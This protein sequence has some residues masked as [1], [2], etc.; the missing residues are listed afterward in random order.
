MSSIDP[1]LE[2]YLYENTQLLEQLE[3]ILLEGEKSM[4]LGQ[5]KIAEV[6]RIM[7]TI[8][9]SSAMMSYESLAH[10]SHAVEDLFSHVR[11]NPPAEQEWEGIFD[12]VL[13]A[14]DFIKE[15]MGKL[16][17][18]ATPDGKADTLIE[19]I[20]S[21]LS[22]L[23]G[24]QSAPVETLAQRQAADEKAAT[25]KQEAKAPAAAPQ[26]SS[27]GN[28]Y[29]LHLAFEPNSKMENIRAFGVLNELTAR[30]SKIASDPED[31]LDSD[32]A[33]D[34]ANR[35]CSMYF[36]STEAP[37]ALHKIIG[38]TLFLSGYELGAIPADSEEIPEAIREAAPA[39]KAEQKSTPA[40]ATPSKASAA[41]A[42]TTAAALTASTPTVDLSKQSFISVNVNRLDKLMDLVGEI[43][44]TESMVTKNPELE[45]LQLD[46][47]EKSAQMLR[48]LTDELQD[49]VM[50]IRMVPISTTFHKMQRLVRD[51]SRKVGKDVDLIIIGEETEIDKSIND[52]LSD[53]LMHMIRNSMDH[54]IESAEDRQAAGKPAKATITLEARN[55]GGDVMVIVSDDGRGL[56]R[57][58]LVAKAT[59]RGLLTKPEAEM[60]DKEV[61]NLILAPGFSTNEN[62]TEYSGRGVG[63]DVVRKNIDKIG[64][65]LNIESTPGQGMTTTI[66]IPL[67]LAIVEGMRIKVGDGAFILPVLS[68]RQSFKPQPGE[69]F[70]DPDGNEMIMIRGECYRILRLHETFRIDDAITTLEE[71]ILI[72]IESEEDTVC[73]FADQLIGEQQAVVKPMPPYILRNAGRLHGMSGCTVLGDGSINLIL[74]VN[75][76]IAG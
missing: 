60:T 25:P 21:F 68:I 39:P 36:K 51:M 52:N 10:L 46:N 11:E 5:E 7:H 2:V 8:K 30:S 16:S 53:P 65:T 14:T 54:G 49:I 72:M 37:E 22:R 12:V 57:E 70:T 63:M 43:V 38:R 29:R 32:T 20:R 73:L 35:G 6:F 48:K 56:N 3:S 44:T 41:P 19:E 13:R 75:A 17:A 1:M 27:S 67:T 59:E 45:G 4:V 71:G 74:D 15:E 42:P 24:K 31:L 23:G 64:G 34:I 50:S 40:A 69:V 9:G 47:F 18:G 58:K 28:F 76:L 26:D 66:R 61:Y 55:T 33:D 62:V